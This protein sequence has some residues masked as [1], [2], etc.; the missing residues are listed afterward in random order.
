MSSI[1][2]DGVASNMTATGANSI[3]SKFN[4]I[5]EAQADLVGQSMRST[6]ADSV[7][8][9]MSSTGANAI[10]NNFTTISS[11][12][13]DKVMAAVDVIGSTQSNLVMNSFDTIGQASANIILNSGNSADLKG[14]VTLEGA[15]AAGYYINIGRTVGM[16]FGLLP[17]GANGSGLG[18]TSTYSGGVHYVTFTSSFYGL[19]SIVATPVGGSGG[20]FSPRITAV[21]GASFHLTP[22]DTTASYYFIGVGTR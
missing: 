18:W 1:M 13:A 19:Y 3:L 17:A 22:P 15:N 20:F 21:T 5:P 10:I 7:G 8:Y 12:Q 2:F 4:S 6:G 14:A 16:I 9:Y 11:S